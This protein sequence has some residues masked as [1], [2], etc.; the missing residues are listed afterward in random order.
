MENQN[1]FGNAEY[2]DTYNYSFNFSTKKLKIYNLREKL[3][4]NVKKEEKIEK[5]LNIKESYVLDTMLETTGV[6]I[7]DKYAHEIKK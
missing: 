6:D 2:M 1:V 4:S 3:E 7:L 5:K